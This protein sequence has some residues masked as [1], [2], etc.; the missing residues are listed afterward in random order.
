M[1]TIDKD[2][3]SLIYK[4]LSKFNY[5][6]PIEKWAK[7]IK[8]HKLINIGKYGSTLPIIFKLPNRAT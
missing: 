1:N 4:E 3:G 7:G 8:K 6:N 5:N 2:P